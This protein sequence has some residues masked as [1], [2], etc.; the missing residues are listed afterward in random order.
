VD[1]KD[2]LTLLGRK[3][4][5]CDKVVPILKRGIA[6]GMVKLEING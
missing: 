3:S 5:L 1:A 2:V 6:A 4:N